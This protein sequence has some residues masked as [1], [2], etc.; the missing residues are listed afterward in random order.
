MKRYGVLLCVLMLA[1]AGCGGG[2]GNGVAMPDSGVQQPDSELAPE[3]EPEPEP[4]PESKPEPE[5]AP[6]P[7]PEPQ[8]QPEPEPEPRA[9]LDE[10]LQDLQVTPA[11]TRAVRILEQADTVLIPGVYASGTITAQGI[12]ESFTVF[13]PKKQ[14]L[15]LTGHG[16]C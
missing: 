11:E 1:L 3:P 2:D 8:P 7:A 9:D 13:E 5:P 16:F 4:G 14:R 12:T 15:C 6:E 10:P